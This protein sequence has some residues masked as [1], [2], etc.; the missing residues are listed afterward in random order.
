M[1]LCINCSVCRLFVCLSSN[2]RHSIK[3]ILLDGNIAAH[4]KG[5]LLQSSQS[6]PF[7]KKAVTC[8][9]KWRYIFFSLIK[10]YRKFDLQHLYG[11]AVLSKLTSLTSPS[12]SLLK[13][14]M[15][16]PEWSFGP[17]N[18]AALLQ[19]F[20]YVWLCLD[21]MLPLENL[22]GSLPS[23]KYSLFLHLLPHVNSCLSH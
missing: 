14:W 20:V 12:D 17:L 15:D 2:L 16:W 13:K 7:M 23:I 6:H 19:S 8:L 10:N 1:A 18:A 21:L 11:V 9:D 5:M 4:L 22:V 3:P